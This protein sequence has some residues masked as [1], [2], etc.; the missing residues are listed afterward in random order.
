[1]TRHYNPAKQIFEEVE[2]T[3]DRVTCNHCGA[4]GLHWKMVT[5]PDGMS[6]NARLFDERNRKHVCTPS[7]DDFS[8]V[9]S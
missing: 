4:Q 8:E 5:A 6:E 7:A 3:D 2:E 9:L 1:V